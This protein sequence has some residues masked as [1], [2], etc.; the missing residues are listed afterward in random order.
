LA[1]LAYY[2]EA[3]VEFQEAAKLMPAKKE[4]ILG[5]ADRIKNLAKNEE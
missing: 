4:E 1:E 3:V 2:S 5:N